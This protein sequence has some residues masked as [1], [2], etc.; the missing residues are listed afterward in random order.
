MVIE[1]VDERVESGVLMVHDGKDIVWE[2]VRSRKERRKLV[3][4]M[5]FLLNIT[6]VGDFACFWVVNL[7]VIGIPEGVESIG[8][9]AFDD[10]CS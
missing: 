5:I 8:Y 6:K 9:A 4:R 7:V 1:R 3:T 2:K 10:C